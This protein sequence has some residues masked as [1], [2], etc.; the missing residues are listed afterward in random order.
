MSKAEKEHLEW[1]GHYNIK[2]LKLKVQSR[3]VNR[4]TGQQDAGGNPDVDPIA[5]EN[6]T[7]VVC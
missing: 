6:T 2:P 3:P 1:G 5:H 7:K 4:Q